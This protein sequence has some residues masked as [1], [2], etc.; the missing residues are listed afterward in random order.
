MD[1]WTDSN[2]TPYMAVMAHWI[3][4]QEVMTAK[5]PIYKLS[6]H[7]DL[8]GFRRV[9]G[10]HTGEHLAGAFIHITDRLNI[11]DKVRFSAILALS[12]F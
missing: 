5:G 11:T 8:I 6:L 2:L 9:P 3:E 10:Q 7:A 4:A 1:M 12:S